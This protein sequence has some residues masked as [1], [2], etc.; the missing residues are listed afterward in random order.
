[1]P[2]MDI[3]D[4]LWDRWVKYPIDKG[5]VP[6]IEAV[7]FRISLRRV[8]F[9]FFSRCMTVRRLLNAVLC[10]FPPMF[11]PSPIATKLKAARTT[12][13]MNPQA[14][15]YIRIHSTICRQSS[16]ESN[17]TS[18]YAMLGGSSIQYSLDGTYLPRVWLVSMESPT[19]RSSMPPS[20]CINRIAHGL[21]MFTPRRL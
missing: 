11:L 5:N 20:W 21:T 9:D 10:H 19:R 3:V 2:S 17:L 12:S 14:P 4:K 15:P 1:M 7:R 6:S 16:Q 8:E 13:A 18:W